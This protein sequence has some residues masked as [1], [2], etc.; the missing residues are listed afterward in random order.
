M[1]MG[2]F[3]PRALPCAPANNKRPRCLLR[4]I[5][6]TNATS[7][8]KHV[9]KCTWAFLTCLPVY[10]AG[11]STGFMH[12][13][14]SVWLRANVLYGHCQQTAR[15]GRPQRFCTSWKKTSHLSYDNLSQLF[16]SPI[17]LWL[18]PTRSQRAE[19]IEEQV[20]ERFSPHLTGSV[21]D[22]GWS[23][24]RGTNCFCKEPEHLQQ[25]HFSF[26][27]QV[28]L[29]TLLEN[30]HPNILQQQILIQTII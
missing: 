16:Q 19:G 8:T 25:L 7:S 21:L 4:L 24:Q 17:D 30:Q 29:A 1:L 5:N 9:C 6:Q 10:M 28:T 15:A 27:S 22:D 3:S 2:S 12:L 18:N 20:E 11:G 13:C 14:V 26:N 23:R